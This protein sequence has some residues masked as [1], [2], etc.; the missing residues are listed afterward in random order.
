MKKNTWAQRM[1]VRV[2][3]FA[4]LAMG[5]LIGTPS[6]TAEAGVI[7]IDMSAYTG[8][9][10]GIAPGNTEFIYEFTPG[11]TSRLDILNMSNAGFLGVL[12]GLSLQ[13][14]P[15]GGIA[16][17]GST[18][19]PIAFGAGA[20]IDANAGGGSYTDTAETYFKGIF[21]ATSPAFA[22]NSFLGFKDSLGRFG[23]IEI[24]WNGVDTFKI[25]SAAYESNPGVAILT[26][27]GEVV[28]EPTSMA[29]FGIGALGMAYRARR[30][31][32]A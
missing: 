20:K 8:N 10:G 25:L 17:A 4:T 23:Y 5:L 16:Y 19:T 6:N 13:Q 3:T 28:P 2:A 32:N 29:I 26:P 24:E 9:N 15:G 21:G 30:K 27:G 12:H 7:P 11:S 31:R 22:P 14:S 18:A 1:V